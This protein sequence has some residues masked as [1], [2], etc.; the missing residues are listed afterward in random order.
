VTGRSF[1]IKFRPPSEEREPTVYFKEYITEL[2]NYLVDDVRD[3]YLVRQRIRK[4]ENVQ[5][6]VGISFQRRDQLKPDV[7]CSVLNTCVQINAQ[8]SLCDRF[9]VKLDR[10]SMP[11]GNSH[12]KTRGRYLD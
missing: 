6:V 3:R 2:N 11:A 4:M 7:I 12:W 8:F 10:V 1:L 5:D 9:E